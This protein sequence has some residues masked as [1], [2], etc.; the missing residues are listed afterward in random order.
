MKEVLYANNAVYGY[1]A[2]WNIAYSRRLRKSG[3]VHSLYP[4]SDTNAN[5]T[6][7]D[8][9]NSACTSAACSNADADADA[10]AG[11]ASSNAR[12]GTSGLH[13]Q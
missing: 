9:T 3:Y 11:S 1:P 10:N 6:R 8:D 13:S 12:D 2:N 4:G 5:N 7:P